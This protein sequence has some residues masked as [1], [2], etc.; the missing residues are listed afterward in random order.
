MYV[1]E[2]IDYLIIY[3]IVGGWELS[4]Y[5]IANHNVITGQNLEGPSN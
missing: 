4:A 2:T 5:R 1:G 3:M